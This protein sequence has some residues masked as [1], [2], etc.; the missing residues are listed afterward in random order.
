MNE[1]A[2]LSAQ[3]AAIEASTE[4]IK[5]LEADVAAERKMAKRWSNSTE[6]RAPTR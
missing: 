4:K 2:S 6:R 5:T 3:L 1:T